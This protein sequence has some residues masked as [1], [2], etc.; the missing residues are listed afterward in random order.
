M[1]VR[2]ILALVICVAEK[3]YEVLGEV[4]YSLLYAAF[5]FRREYLQDAQNKALTKARKSKR[6]PTQS[7]AVFVFGV[8]Q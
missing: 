4:A 1:H 5:A 8:S 6:H 2:Q 7:G 3:A